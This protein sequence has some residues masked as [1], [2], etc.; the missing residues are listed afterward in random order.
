MGSKFYIYNEIENATISATSENASFPLSN[1]NDS[2][3]TKVFRS[4]SN[5]DSIT[6]DFGSNRPIDSFVIVDH[7]TNGFKLSSIT[8]Q[9]N[10]TN[11]WTSPA[12]SQVVTLDNKFGIGKINFTEG[13]YRFAR[14]VLTSTHGFCEVGKIFIGKATTYQNIDLS[15]PLELDNNNLSTISKNK[16]GQRFID[17]VATQRKIKSSLDYMIQSEVDDVMEWTSFV[18]S[19]KPFFFSID[20]I[21]ALSEPNRL[22]GMYF[23]NASPVFQ[24][25]K[26][27]LWSC[28][29]SLEEAM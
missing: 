28:S 11:V 9:L 23:L 12:F 19:S 8:L 25:Q 20:E 27:N 2:R 26:G 13:N 24:L 18:S 17:E 6:F 3:R 22:N 10:G 7:I 29:I 15:Y 5:T 16:Y 21:Q 14:L 1:L 4:N